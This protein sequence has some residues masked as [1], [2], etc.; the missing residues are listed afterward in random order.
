MTNNSNS[1]HLCRAGLIALLAVSVTAAAA[2]GKNVDVTTQCRQAAGIHENGFPEGVPTEKAVI[3]CEEAGI[4][5]PEDADVPAYLARAYY[6]RKSGQQAFDAARRSAERGSAVGMAVFGV[7]HEF[8][9]GT[10][11]DGEAA[12]Q[13]YRR[14]A[15]AGNAWAQSNLANMLE[16]GVAAPGPE[17]SA[18]EWY[19]KAAKQEFPL[20]ARKLGELYLAGRGGASR[21]D[22]LAAEWLGRAASN[23]DAEAK[24]LLGTLYEKGRGIAKDEVLAAELYRLAAFPDGHGKAEYRLARLLEAKRAAAS[25]AAEYVELYFQS[26]EHKDASAERKLWDLIEKGV[27]SS[28][29]ASRLMDGLQARAGRNDP[30]GQAML[31]AAYLYGKLVPADDRLAAQWLEKAAPNNG[32]AAAMIGSMY[33]VG[34]G[35]PQ[36]HA[37]AIELWHGAKA[38]A[39]SLFLT[40]LLAYWLEDT[41]SG[42]SDALVTALIAALALILWGHNFRDAR[43]EGLP[44]V[45]PLGGREPSAASESLAAP[46]G[47]LYALAIAC[48]LASAVL[49][50]VRVI[51][52]NQLMP[53]PAI[54]LNMGLDAH[55]IAVA[56]WHDDQGRA[57]GGIIEALAFLA[58]ATGFWGDRNLAEVDW[59]ATTG[60]RIGYRGRRM[61]S[62]AS[63]GAIAKSELAGKWCFFKVWRITKS[64]GRVLELPSQYWETCAPKLQAA[65]DARGALR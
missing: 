38:V 32:A 14:G 23:G 49:L 6:A 56:G 24:Y 15:A 8:G 18:F 47:W 30:T 64:D 57:W 61:L 19:R 54:D 34:R 53:M 4:K 12:A 55:R 39:H 13:W 37:K 50:L 58:L 25:H 31:G 51:E 62:W 43:R 35:V 20:A 3:L 42:P 9:L 40:N 65:I 21:D 2:A 60:L 63:P 44:M 5:A 41:W 7:V 48:T 36:N 17:E 1:H 26:A 45:L 52:L 33:F 46:S 28:D 10:R 22:K 29:A 27:P 59:D 11:K 16:N